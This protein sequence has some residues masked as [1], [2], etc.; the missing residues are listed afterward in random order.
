MALP[1][2]QS[3]V[4][5][6]LDGSEQEQKDFLERVGFYKRAYQG[7]RNQRKTVI[8]QR[9]DFYE[10]DQTKYTNIY[11]KSAKMRTG[12]VYPVF[13][14]SAASA[15]KLQLSLINYPPGVNV[16]PIDVNDPVEVLKTQ[17]EEAFIDRLL[18]DNKFK[19]VVFPRG[20]N[21]QSV[22]GNFMLKTYLDNNGEDIK[23]VNIEKIENA[24]AAWRGD[25]VLEFDMALVE[26]VLPVD[27][28]ERDYG[29]K[30]APDAGSEEAPST[31]SGHKDPYSTHPGARDA[32]MI[33]KQPHGKGKV[34]S[35]FVTEACDDRYYGVIIN[36]EIVHFVKHDY[37][38]NLF[39]IGHNRFNNAKSWS[40][41]DIDDLMDVQVELNERS[42]DEADMIRAGSNLKYVVVNMPEFDAESVKAGEA[43]VIY[44]DGEGADFRSLRLDVQVFPSESYLNR[45]MDHIYNLGVPRVAFAVG[46]KQSSGKALSVEYQSVVEKIDNKRTQWE[47]V[48]IS[49]LD[50]AR[51]IA[52]EHWGSRPEF[53]FLKNKDGKYANRMLEFSWDDIEPISRSDRVVDVLNL[54]NAGVWP[55]RKM[56]G[57]LKEKDPGAIITMLKDEWSDP[58]LSAI[59][60]KHYEMTK[61]LLEAQARLAEVQLQI[62]QL[63]LANQ[64]PTQPTG[65]EVP[66]GG[67]G[68]TAYSPTLKTS[69]N[70]GRSVMP[71]GGG[72]GSTASPEGNL[73]AQNQ[74]AS[75][76][77]V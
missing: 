72:M 5:R 15:D 43:Q 11:L 38:F 19:Y 26:L 55:L 33:M 6:R 29:F 57:D 73:A 66:V 51:K 61:G 75:A 50:K 3:K 22:T 24:Y 47:M 20:A 35:A 12:H 16:K 21:N 34:P 77:G 42:G 23:I 36:N 64:P 62:A 14:Y 41:G 4:N 31:Q 8:S 30:A 59:R 44:I 70:T 56:Y 48:M 67:A 71:A 46:G 49:V 25:D 69:Q 58:E 28:V 13:N 2:M 60:S 40:K 74:N 52:F 68:N 65:G 53:D 37:G 45:V 27:V 7:E 10:G 32:G 9:R 18:Y 54:Y 17:M 1:R 39:D 63:N 76:A